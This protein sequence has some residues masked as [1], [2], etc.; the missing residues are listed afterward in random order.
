MSK[1][2]QG[3]KRKPKQNIIKIT[4]DMF[5]TQEQ[6][7][8]PPPNYKDPV[9]ICCDM[10]DDFDLSIHLESSLKKVDDFIKENIKD[11]NYKVITHIKKKGEIIGEYIMRYGL[12]SNESTINISS[13]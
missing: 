6:P 12:S 1:K 2:K 13:E 9:I 3:H 11:P 10:N 7:P 8:P 5:K 4:P